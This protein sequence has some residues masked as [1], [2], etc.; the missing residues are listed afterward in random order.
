[1]AYN[2]TVSTLD[3]APGPWGPSGRRQ[4]AAARNG[5]A[6]VR[7]ALAAVALTLLPG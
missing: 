2:R 5:L 6:T 3:D 7:Y 1:M 4:S